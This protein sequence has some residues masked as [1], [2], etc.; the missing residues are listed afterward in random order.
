MNKQDPCLFVYEALSIPEAHFIDLIDSC[1]FSVVQTNKQML[2]C[3]AIISNNSPLFHVCISKTHL[4]CL[5]F[6]FVCK[7]H[8]INMCHVICFSDTNLFLSCFSPVALANLKLCFKAAFVNA[9]NIL[10]IEW[11]LSFIENSEHS[12][13]ISSHSIL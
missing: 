9:V 2:F 3:F 6:P 12:L 11:S 4:F 5:A 1:K 10:N 7:F 8:N 13:A